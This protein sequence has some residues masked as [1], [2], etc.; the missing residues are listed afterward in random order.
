MLFFATAGACGWALNDQIDSPPWLGGNWE[1]EGRGLS[2][3]EGT[4]DAT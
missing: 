4:R 3:E 1:V 2:F